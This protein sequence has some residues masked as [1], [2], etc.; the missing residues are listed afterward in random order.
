MASRIPS[1]NW[2]RVFEA[3]AR[4]ESFARAAQQLNMSAAAVSQQVKALESQ[5]GAR[6]FVRHPHSVTLTEAGR[7]YLPSVQQS[8]LMLETATTGLFG[9]TRQ[10]RVFVQSNMLF[11]HGFLAA[12][13]PVFNET[14]PDVRVMLGTSNQASESAS[15]FTD[16]QI[17]FGNPTLFGAS[18]D[19]LLEERL[20]PMAAPEVAERIN[21]PH[22]LL[23]HV[24]IEVASHR[25]GWPYVFKAL[26]LPRGSLRHTFVDNTILASTMAAAG[27][28]VCLAR[29]PASDVITSLSGL[30]PCLPGFEVPGQEGYHLVYSDKPSLR[31]AALVFRNWLLDYLTE[32]GHPPD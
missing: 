19:P 3:A 26:K 1:L 22:D 9:E 27:G 15:Q 18:H 30:M 25:A 2:L 28:G 21:S 24:L 29:S 23:D 6:L 12:G 13:I 4:T 11:A 5:L 14:H 16:L 17:V 32:N 10:Q 31:P 7:G 20:F 8:L